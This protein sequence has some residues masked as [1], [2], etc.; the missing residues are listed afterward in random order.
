MLKGWLVL[1][2][3]NLLMKSEYKVKLIK[4]SEIQELEKRINSEIEK[5]RKEGFNFKDIKQLNYDR[6]AGYLF[7]LVFYK[8]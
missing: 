6:Y 2:I 4:W 7:I 5:F 3:K 1:K 8:L